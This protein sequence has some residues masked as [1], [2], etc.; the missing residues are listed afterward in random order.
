MDKVMYILE[1]KILFKIT[2]SGKERGAAAV[3]FA[4]ILPILVTLLLGIAQFGILFNHYLTLTHAARE[5]VRWAALEQPVSV[6]KTKTIAAA[7]SLSMN[8]SNV[9]VILDSVVLADTDK[10]DIEDQ[11][12]PVVV[13]VY[14]DSPVLTYFAWAF[15]GSDHIT[16]TGR[17]V[18]KVE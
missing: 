10:A 2:M 11:G 18:Q 14:Y 8:S 3:E 7:T 4:L 5:G 9:K 13:E 12:K 15:S 16:L 17:A 6:V 1:K